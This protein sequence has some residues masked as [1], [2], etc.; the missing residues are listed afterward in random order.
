M[1]VLGS[2]FSYDWGKFC[3]YCRRL[4]LAS[5]MSDSS[6]SIPPPRTTGGGWRWEPPTPAELQEIMPQYEVQMLVGRGGMGAVYKGMQLSLDRAVAI[7]LLPPAIERQDT[8][9]AERFKNEAKL[10]GRMNHPAIV[11][12]YDF[13]RTSDGQLYFVMEYVDGTD[14]QRMIAREGKLPPEHALAITAHLC[15]ALGYAHKQGVVHRDIKPSNVL[16]DIEGRVKVADFG[17]AKLSDKNLNS[18]LTQTGMAM[19]TPDYVAPETL[20]FGSDVDGRA[21]IYA[22]GVMLYQMLTGDIPRGMFKM[23]SQKFRSI[24]PRFD[25][26]VRRALE[27]DREERYQTSHELRLALDVILTTPRAEPGQESSA[28]LPK[29]PAH[30]P[31]RTVVPSARNPGSSQQRTHPR[32]EPPYQPPPPPHKAEP[33]STMP[34]VIAALLMLGVGGWFI[35]NRQPTAIPHNPS[36]TAETATAKAP[37]PKSIPTPPPEPP[38]VTPKTTPPSPP[39]K[40]TPG[41]ASIP[42]VV[43][44]PTT[45]PRPV[46]TP[47]APAVSAQDT[48]IYRLAQLESQFQTAFERDVNATYADQLATLGAGYSTALDRAML[49][50]SKA[51]RL[52]ETIALRE[53]KQRF[54]TH[55]FMPSIDPSSLHKAVVTLRNAYRTAEKK[56]AQQ[57]DATSLPLYDRYIEVLT[58]L[59]KEVLSQGRS[60]DASAVRIKRDDVT[61]RRKQRA[62]KVSADVSP[63][64]SSTTRLTLF[65]GQSLNG[66][67]II[68]DADSFTVINGEIRSNS[69][70]GNLIYVGVSG[71]V[72][73]WKDF[74]V[75]M[76]IKCAEQANSGI[77]LAG[78]VTVLIDGKPV[79]EWSFPTGWVP[80]A[81][82]ND[83]QTF[84]GTIG[85]Q[86]LSGSI[87]FKDITVE[88]L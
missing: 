57:K 21:D 25:A 46:V 23:P 59:E 66:W 14:V 47:T 61:A 4:S 73:S 16:I 22:V 65:D 85:L 53:E 34:Y 78:L 83:V 5:A 13:G 50:A 67:R 27:H 8:A 74:T 38:P 88:L 35:V 36:E 64:P 43:M 41:S 40:S 82:K 62:A 31:G 33:S 68:G 84:Q 75:E 63:T 56:Y 28:V 60:A 55:K 26:I 42:P 76:R 3:Y 24:D 29:Q 1:L 18:G 30:T 70:P 12:V 32:H 79:N 9:F 19:G 87:A 10:M 71:V 7:K 69:R 11:S 86:S 49:D 52:D 37:V 51:G 15:D 58:S 45:P 72:P 44:A 77:W 17:L 54:T 48:I 80:P 39:V 20:T 6:N 2:K 81:D